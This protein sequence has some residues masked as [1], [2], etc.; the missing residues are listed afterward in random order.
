MTVCAS[1]DLILDQGPGA[2]REP[3]VRPGRPTSGH[4]QTPK[5]ADEPTLSRPSCVK[6]L[7]YFTALSSAI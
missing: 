5:P 3:V 1:G 4:L 7:H 6:W 2:Q